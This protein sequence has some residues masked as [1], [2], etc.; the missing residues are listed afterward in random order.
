MSVI[1][2]PL[3]SIPATRS[4]KG[5]MDDHGVAYMILCYRLIRLQGM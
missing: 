2:G 3:W 1:K 4:Q 5:G